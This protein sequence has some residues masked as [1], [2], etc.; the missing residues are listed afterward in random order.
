MDRRTDL[1]MKTGMLIHFVFSFM[2]AV[3]IHFRVT[4]HRK[5]PLE[6]RFFLRSSKVFNL[7]YM[8]LTWLQYFA[9][10]EFRS[11]PKIIYKKCMRDWGGKDKQLWEFSNHNVFT[12][13]LY[14]IADRVK[15]ED[16]RVEGVYRQGFA[17]VAAGS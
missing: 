4:D 9:V 1:R 13:A 10:C 11:S 17:V 2:L 12:N 14:Q 8:L 5:S 6:I 15:F 7:W 3:L 16:N